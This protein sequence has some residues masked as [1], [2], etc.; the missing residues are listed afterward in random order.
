[1]PDPI[2]LADTSSLDTNNNTDYN[3]KL[4]Q[5]QWLWLHHFSQ[6]QY[7]GIDIEFFQ[8]STAY[9]IQLNSLYKITLSL[10]LFH[11]IKNASNVRFE[12]ENPT[13]I[14]LNSI[15]VSDRCAAAALKWGWQLLKGYIQEKKW[16]D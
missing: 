1:M 3:F 8:L 14:D 11:W 7:S 13:K 6:S 4:G 12:S 16:L 15:W 5:R 9:Q 2:I 10:K